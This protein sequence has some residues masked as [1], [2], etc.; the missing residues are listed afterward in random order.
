[1]YPQD[2]DSLAQNFSDDEKVI[3]EDSFEIEG[4]VVDETTTKI[5]RD[6]YNIFFSYWEPPSNAENFTVLLSEKPLPRLGTIITIRI[7]SLDVFQEFIQPRYDFI[8]ERA[9]AGVQ[10]VYNYL[11]NWDEIQKELQGED[12]QGTGIY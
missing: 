11:E 3:A 7:N 2:I 5:G 1:M 10:A 9:I 8:E 12:L 4:L 6:F